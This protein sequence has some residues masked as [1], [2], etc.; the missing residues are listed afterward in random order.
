MIGHMFF[1]KSLKDK[2]GGTQMSKGNWILLYIACLSFLFIIWS[3][4]FYFFFYPE[5]PRNY[6]ILEKINR[7]PSSLLGE[8]KYS[9]S[10]KE[11][12]A[13][14]YRLDA[15]NIQKINRSLL[16][17]Y[18]PRE[19]AKNIYIQPI[20]V[21][22]IKSLSS[23]P[24]EIDIPWKIAQLQALVPHHYKKTLSPFPL[25]LYHLIPKEKSIAFKKG[26]N[27]KF[28]FR[29][30]PI[31]LQILEKNQDLGLQMLTI[32]KADSASPKEKLSP[33]EIESILN[34]LKND[35]SRDAPLKL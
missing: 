28:H 20:G 21:F 7:I 29:N 1:R 35:L 5:K 23:L 22:K 26:K 4:S 18:T 34:R 30:L 32:Q 10:P 2:I 16:R 33:P 31:L 24:L 6:T 27:K 9:L 25:T 13:R 3:I 15:K 12:L 11:I 14:T 8:K 17:Q 19:F